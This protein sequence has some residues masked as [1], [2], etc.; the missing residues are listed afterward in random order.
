PAGIND[1]AFNSRP[2]DDVELR[3]VLA[4]L[5]FQTRD[6]RPRGIA[7]FHD[8]L[9]KQPDNVVANRDLGYAALQ[10]DDWDRAEQYFKRAAAAD[11]KD[12]EVHYLVAFGLSHKARSTGRPPEDLE[13]MKKELNAAITLDPNYADAY[14]LLGMILA[15]SDDKESAIATLKKAIALN[16]RYDWNYANLAKVD[17]RAQDFDSAVPLF[18]HLI[19]SAD[20][21]I[22]AMAQQQI[23]SIETYKQ[24]LARW[25]EQSTARGG[26]ITVSTDEDQTD[27]TQ[28]ASN[29]RDG[30]AKAEPVLFM[31]GILNAVDC[32]TSPSAILTITSAGKRWKM[33]APEAKKLVVIGADS[34]SCS[35]TNKKVAVNYRKTGTN[36]GQLVT[37][38]LE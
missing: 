16:P 31:K 8:I 28:P 19:S 34:L 35:W 6:Y 36:E 12:P 4:D 32:S 27:G 30:S 21:Q 13:T 38:E 23:Q 3:T 5:D 11:S 9:S 33:V 2:L 25:K 18:Q 20:P 22:S 15:S 24:N 37:V 7:T 17:M 1:I 14:G 29:L 10:Q 26:N